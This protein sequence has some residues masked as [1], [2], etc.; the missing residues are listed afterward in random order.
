MINMTYTGWSI[1][2]GPV[3]NGL[4]WPYNPFAVVI[5][6]FDLRIQLIGKVLVHFWV[7]QLFAR[8]GYVD[9]C[10]LHQ[11]LNY[12][13]LI[14]G[15]TLIFSIFGY[16]FWPKNPKSPK[17]AKNTFWLMKKPLNQIFRVKM[18]PK[19]WILN[20]V[21]LL[22]WNPENFEKSQKSSFSYQNGF[23]IGQNVVLCSKF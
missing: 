5:L 3:Q 17:M 15:C 7:L 13:L 22:W 16:I 8:T 2:I 1:K 23:K 20:L 12:M 10:T 14:K 18:W 21:T 6:Y 11:S 4:E 19:G 9:F